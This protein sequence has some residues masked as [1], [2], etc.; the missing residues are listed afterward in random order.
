EKY[1]IIA[2]FM[3]ELPTSGYSINIDKIIEEKMGVKVFLTETMP[4]KDCQVNQV[5]TYP[6]QVVKVPKISKI[7]DFIYNKVVEDCN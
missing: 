5:F 3:G 4:G 7:V 6:Y 1:T 2:V